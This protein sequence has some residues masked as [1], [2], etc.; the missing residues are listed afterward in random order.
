MSRPG[1]FDFIEFDN[2]EETGLNEEA[3]FPDYGACNDEQNTD[4]EI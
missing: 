2:R 4:G 1:W 3:I